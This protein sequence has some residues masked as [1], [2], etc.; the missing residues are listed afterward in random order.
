[1]RSMR[2]VATVFVLCFATAGLYAQKQVILTATIT[3]PSGAE[4]TSIDPM[5]VTFSEN[6]ADGTVLKV[7]PA[8]AVVPKV[9]ILIDN[10]LGIPSASLG[11][12]R[13]AVKGLINALPTTVETTLVTT[14]PQPRMLEKATT[15]RVK[16]L[17]AVDRLT[18]DSS[19]GKFVDSMFEATDRAVKDKTEGASYTIIALASSSGDLNYRESDVKQVAQRVQQKRIN[20]HVVILS[21]LNNASGGGIQVDL[22]KGLADMSSGRFES[23]AVANRLVTLLPEIGAQA[24]KAMAPGAKQFRITLQRPA[25]ATGDLG[26]VRIGV[27][28]KLLSNAGF[29]ATK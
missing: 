17:S 12:L 13:T 18:P 3:D 15:D 16:L 5:D 9:Q 24:A 6:G 10:G 27:K 4:V 26:P 22:G 11:D 7:E 29:Q 1:M 19:T 20:V 21:S 23:I 14:A 25:N 2:L 28:G 8:A